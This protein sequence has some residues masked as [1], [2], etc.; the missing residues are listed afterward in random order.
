MYQE[1]GQI[2]QQLV[3]LVQAA[4]NGDQEAGQQIEQIMQA[5]QQGDVRAQKYAMAIQKIA[6]KLQAQAQQQQ[7]PVMAREGG[8]IP[9]DKCGDKMKYLKALKGCKAKKKV[10]KD[11]DGKKVG[12][13]CSCILKRVG[14]RI[15]KVDSCTE[16][17]IEDQDIVMAQKG[18]G[19]YYRYVPIQ[20]EIVVSEEIP[21]KKDNLYVT[22]DSKNSKDPIAWNK[23]RMDEDKVRW[24][25]ENLNFMGFDAGDEDGKIGKKTI[26][27]I[28]EFQRSAGL[29][30]DGLFGSKTYDAFW[31]A[32]ARSRYDQSKYGL[33]VNEEGILDIGQDLPT[34]E[35]AKL[36]RM[37]KQNADLAIIRPEIKGITV[38]T[39]SPT[40]SLN[41]LSRGTN[42]AQLIK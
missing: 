37:K 40:A 33:R 19:L 32:I 8:E 16:L 6:Q 5:A 23:A 9:A 24:I 20:H 29:K 27:A 1:G 4:M 7:Q 12:K 21:A 18:S 11:A 41:G 13:P 3:A 39:V 38:K 26:E 36:A 17:P 28:K 14:G 42:Y 25:Q 2:Q 31:E 15:I 10:A 35:E 34:L 22:T 30:D